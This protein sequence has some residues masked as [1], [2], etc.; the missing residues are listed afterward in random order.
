MGLEQSMRLFAQELG[1]YCQGHVASYTDKVSL[2]MVIIRQGSV[3][4][5]LL[6]SILSARGQKIRQIPVRIGLAESVGEHPGSASNVYS[7]CIQFFVYA[8]HCVT[9]PVTGTDISTSMGLQHCAVVLI[10][11]MSIEPRE[12]RLSLHL[13]LAGSRHTCE[14]RMFHM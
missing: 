4:M 13:T 6:S 2:N 10:E 3:R 9:G 12:D 1:A 8:F 11:N 14:R 5:F 7:A